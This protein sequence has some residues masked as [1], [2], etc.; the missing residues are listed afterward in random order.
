M[1]KGKSAAVLEEIPA[2]E[3]SPAKPKPIFEL[4]QEF[5]DALANHPDCRVLH[6]DFN[7][8]PGPHEMFNDSNREAQR[9]VSIRFLMRWPCRG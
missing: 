2:A 1:A 7:K 3:I 5:Y 8:R 6:A 9:D 4:V